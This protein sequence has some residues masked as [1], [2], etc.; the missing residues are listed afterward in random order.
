M[1]CSP[2]AD[3]GAWYRGR[4]RGFLQIPSKLLAGH[5]WIIM[6]TSAPPSWSRQVL[7]AAIKVSGNY[8]GLPL[9]S[10]HV[11][12]VITWNYSVRFTLAV[13]GVSVACGSQLP[14]FPSSG[15][16]L[17]NL[18]QVNK[19]ITAFKHL[20]SLS[21]V[22]WCANILTRLALLTALSLL[23]GSVKICME[24]ETYVDITW[25]LPDENYLP[26]R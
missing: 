21:Y 9:D 17:V 15:M 6:R 14:F 18:S 12:D 23:R 1:L 3:L 24:C 8:D 4:N 22:I 10:R 11:A 25:Q 20:S 5:A 16:I 7:P 19:G 2:V 26:S 13:S